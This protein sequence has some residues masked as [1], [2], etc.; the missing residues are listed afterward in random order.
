MGNYVADSNNLTIRAR[1]LL[2]VIVERY[3]REGKP[4]GSRVLAREMESELSPATLRNTIADLENMGFLTAPHTSAGRVPTVLG[5]RYFVDHLMILQPPQ[6]SELP[7]WHTQCAT[8]QSID[9]LVA[10]T[11]TWLSDVTHFA[12]LVMV[13]RPD[14]LTLRHV[15]F[16]PLSERRILTI[17]VVNDR[18]VRHRIIDTERVYKRAEL[19][20]A[21]Q[22]LNDAYAGQTLEAIR[23]Q[24][25]Q[26]MHADRQSMDSALVAIG[27][28]AFAPMAA[29]D[30][31]L[32]GKENLLS[33][34]DIER[35]E[36]LQRL[37]EAFNRKRDILHLLERFLAAGEHTQ[38]V[39]GSESGCIIF[40][41]CSIVAAPYAAA[42]QVLGMVAVIGPTRMPYEKVFPVVELAA[43]FLGTALNHHE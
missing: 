2:K 29:D 34:L 32:M 5:Y 37:F 26:E 1:Q 27:S 30:Y 28:R 39:I 25:T 4:V 16:M 20:K 38:A 12:G 40:E 41:Q 6:G 22:Y 13:P 8:D 18:E 7:D 9:E 21:A 15:A 31:V 36:E 14:A 10:A 35:R 33:C 23:A 43:T 3:I 42:G 19:D 24:I 17:L 11:S